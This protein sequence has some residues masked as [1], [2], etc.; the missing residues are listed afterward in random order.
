[1]NLIDV[2]EFKARRLYT[3]LTLDLTF[4]LWAPTSAPC[5]IAVVTEVLVINPLTP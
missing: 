1:M 2:D 5:T 4:K 3:G